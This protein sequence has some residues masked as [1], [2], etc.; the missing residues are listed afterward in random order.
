MNASIKAEQKNTQNIAQDKNLYIIIGVTLISIMGGQTVAPILPSLTEVFNVSTREIELVMTLFV[1]PI[2]IATPI[3]GVLAD[4]IGIRKVLIPALILFA[5][6]GASIAFANTFTSVIGLRFVQGL[7]AAPLDALSLTMIAMLYQG[8]MLGTAMSINAAV[9]GISS[10]I[11]PLVGGALGSLSWSYPFLLSVLAFPLVM[12][13]IMVLKL[14]AKPATAKKESLKVYLK[15]TWKSV[16]NRSV[17]GLLFAVGSIFMIQFGAFITYVPIFAGVELGSSGFVNGIILC[18]MSLAVAISASQLGW[19]IQRFSEI[20]LIKA[21]FILSAVALVMIP[22]M[23]NPWMLLIPN[24]LFGISLAFALPSSQA[25]LAGLSA[26]DSRAGFMAVNAS[27]QSLGQALGPILGAVAI[28]FGGIKVVFLTAAVYSVIA[29]FI[30][31]ILITPKQT[32][33]VPVVSELTE[34]LTFIPATDSPTILQ[35]PVAQLVHTLTNQ[36]I[37]LPEVPALINI[38]KHRDRSFGID[39]SNLPNSELVSRNH[40]QIK[41]DG[42]DYYIQD[43]GSSN[44]TYINKYPLLPGIWYK[45]GPGVKLGLGKRDM[46]AFIF[47]FS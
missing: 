3:L 2:G 24:V 39:V 22:F 20:T 37:D 35:A 14:P 45:L 16:N 19:L 40:A 12:L 11:Y 25:L 41:F 34:E 13:V 38:G 4:R 23:P 7:G 36:V 21:S 6:A 33:P 32:Q 47:Q 1:L 28:T 43:M 44:G 26:Q 18:V 29:F 8:R 17:L 30:F 10:A 46:I 31:N 42:E 5:I 9:I 15:G 27:V